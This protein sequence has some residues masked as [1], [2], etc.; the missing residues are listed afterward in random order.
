MMI[1]KVVNGKWTQLA[2]TTAAQTST[3]PGIHAAGD[4]N[5]DGAHFRFVAKGSVLTGLVSTDG[6]KTYTQ[7]LQASDSELKAGLIGVEHFDYGPQF[8]DL[9]VEDAP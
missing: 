3:L 2:A 8:D 4:L 7:V 9:L 1:M 5:A 6:G